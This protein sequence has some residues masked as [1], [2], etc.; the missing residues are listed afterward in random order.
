MLGGSYCASQFQTVI[1]T[2]R[3]NGMAKSKGDII[4][5]IDT[6]MK[7][8]RYKNSDWYVGIA[9]VPRARLFIDHT[10]DEKNGIWIYEPATSDSVARAVEQAYLDAGHDGGS[11]GGDSSTIYFYAYVKLQETT[12]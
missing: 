10:V 6:Y 4:A 12:R 9:S 2:R 1:Q 8:F 7:K 3:R 11:G 5:V